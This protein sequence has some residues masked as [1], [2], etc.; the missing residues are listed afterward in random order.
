MISDRKGLH[1]KSRRS[2]LSGRWPKR[3]WAERSSAIEEGN[4][5]ARRAA[6]QCDFSHE[7]NGSITKMRRCGP[8]GGDRQCSNARTWLHQDHRTPSILMKDCS[9]GD[10]YGD[11]PDVSERNWETMRTSIAGYAR[12][13]RVICR[14][15]W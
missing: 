4:A 10:G 1:R 12:Y 7:S 5:A 2:S 13:K 9:I 6:V 8:R 11:R 15:R 14:Q 3:G